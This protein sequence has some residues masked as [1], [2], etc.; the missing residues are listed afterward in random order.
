MRQRDG[1]TREGLRGVGIRSQPNP[2]NEPNGT[3]GLTREKKKVAAEMEG[4]NGNTRCSERVACEQ[5][6]SRLLTPEWRKLPSRRHTHIARSVVLA[7][8]AAFR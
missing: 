7:S 3:S 2:R 4:Q 1:W 5:I 6:T 8:V